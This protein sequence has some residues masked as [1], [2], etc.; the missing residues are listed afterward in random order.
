MSW[1]KGTSNSHL[2]V[3]DIEDIGWS[4]AG[5]FC[6]I[7]IYFSRILNTLLQ[8][9]FYS[10]STF[11]CAISNYFYIY[12]ELKN[13]FSFVPGLLSWRAVTLALFF[14]NT[15]CCFSTSI[16][17]GVQ[18]C[19]F[20]QLWKPTASW[21][22]SDEPSD[23]GQIWMSC[24]IMFLAGERRY[25]LLSQRT[26]FRVFYSSLYQSTSDNCSLTDEHK[27]KP[28]QNKSPFCN[29]MASIDR[30]CK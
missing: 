8:V 25:M 7:C 5:V 16:Q 22:A 17:G 19:T 9:I 2:A 12:N 4:T 1:M 27:C 13:V 26:T 14:I 21:W 24:S 20:E 6:K 10:S 30:Y 3:C 15:Y 28:K 23:Q 29:V 11:E 18:T